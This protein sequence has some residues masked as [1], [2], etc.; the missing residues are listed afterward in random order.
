MTETNGS[1]DLVQATNMIDY[2]ESLYN[3]AKEAGAQVEGLS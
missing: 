1:Y 2:V 3:G